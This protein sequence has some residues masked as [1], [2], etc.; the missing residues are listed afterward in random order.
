[1]PR[2]TP[3]DPAL[4]DAFRV[5]AGLASGHSAS[6]LRGADLSRPYRGVRMRGG[7]DGDPPGVRA[8]R[9]YA[10][11]LRPGDRFSGPT[12]AALW[13][14]PLPHDAFPVHVTAGPGLG[15]PRRVGVVGHS[16]RDVVAASRL[17]LPVSPP[18]LAFLECAGELSLGELVAIGDH[19]VLDPRVLDPR[20]IRPYLPLAELR[21]EVVAAGY[22][23]VRVRSRGLGVDR[24]ET[25]ARLLRAFAR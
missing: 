2:R 24:D 17:G 7:V 13:G 21:R 12:A 23:M 15:R 20:D 3:L 10:P 16:G 18:A 1:M 5:G 22:R 14:A 9:A 8:A 25:V 6:R 4:G 11:L 19:L